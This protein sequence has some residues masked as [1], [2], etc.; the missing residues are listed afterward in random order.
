[1]LRVVPLLLAMKVRSRME[2]RA[3]FFIDALAMMLTYGSVYATF[4]ILLLRF[5]TLAG[6][7]WP[8]LA[9]LLSFQLFTYAVGASFSFTQFRDMEEMVRLGQL[10]ALLVKPFSPWA[11]LTFSG[12]NIGYIAPHHTCHWTDGLGGRPSRCRPGAQVS[13]YILWPPSSAPR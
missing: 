12:Y 5:E 13:C 8:E 10:D 6:W 2:Y 4:W 1:M 7:D 11:Y 9:V 3:S